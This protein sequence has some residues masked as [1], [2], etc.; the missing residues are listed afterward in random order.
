MHLTA[1]L[2]VTKYIVSAAIARLRGSK[3]RGHSILGNLRGAGSGDDG[4]YLLLMIST[5]LMHATNKCLG[6]PLMDYFTHVS[7]LFDH[8]D[9]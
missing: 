3:E 5:P 1:V 7:L 8:T 2:L 4:P 6:A 9:I